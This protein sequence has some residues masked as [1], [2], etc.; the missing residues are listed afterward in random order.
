MPTRERRAHI[1]GVSVDKLPDGR[2]K[3]GNHVRGSRHHRWNDSK[4]MSPNG[5]PMIRVGRTHPLADPNGYVMEH[6]LVVASALGREAISG[7]V[8]HHVDG[9]RTNNRIENLMLLTIAEHNKI[10]NAERGRH[11]D[12]GRFASG[13]RVLDGRTWE[14]FPE[15]GR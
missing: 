11:G 12:T 5:Y 3:H 7:K 6:I 8:I 9:D 4:I 15:V 2:G 10:H 14:Q 1:L 13:S